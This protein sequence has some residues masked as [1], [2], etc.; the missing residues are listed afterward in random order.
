[1]PEDKKKVHFPKKPIKP[2][3]GP[4]PEPPPTPFVRKTLGPLRFVRW[5]KESIVKA[6]TWDESVFKK[7]SFYIWCMGISG[8]YIG[9]IKS[10][11][12]DD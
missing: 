1:M 5:T 2:P 8:Y 6:L 12:D 11:T 9:F 7:G 4:V 3:S 10:R